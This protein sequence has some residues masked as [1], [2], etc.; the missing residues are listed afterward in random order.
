MA[1]AGHR[2]GLRE[3]KT[4][5]VAY[6]DWLAMSIQ[7]VSAPRVES[8]QASRAFCHRTTSTQKSKFFFSTQ[9]INAK[10]HRSNGASTHD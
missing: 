3:S 6:R 7:P 5:A 9:G 1:H 2:T 8:D 10:I 4:G